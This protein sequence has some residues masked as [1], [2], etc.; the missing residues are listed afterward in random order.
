MFVDTAGIP[1]HDIT[2]PPKARSAP[3]ARRRWNPARW[4]PG[5]RSAVAGR[6]E[7]T[8]LVQTRFPP[9]GIFT[10][11]ARGTKN[12][13][14]PSRSTRD[15]GRWDVRMSCYWDV[16]I[17]A[18][19]RRLDSWRA[20]F[21]YDFTPILMQSEQQVSPA[22]PATTVN[23]RRDHALTTPR[24][25]PIC[26]R[27][28]MLG[29]RQTHVVRRAA[30]TTWAMKGQSGNHGQEAVPPSERDPQAPVGSNRRARLASAVRFASFD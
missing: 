30:G 9:G 3:P 26:R 1:P 16:G 15:R 7:T 28:S 21:L 20:A 12:R 18:I 14:L 8:L 24:F 6:L 17:A 19:A 13:D 29:A 27:A 23:A 22:V 25:R 5:R 4:P 2:P 11:A 10:V